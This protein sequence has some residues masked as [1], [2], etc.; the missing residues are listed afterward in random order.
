MTI[1]SKKR[2]IGHARDYDV[3]ETPSGRTL[4]KYSGSKKGDYKKQKFW[5][6][7]R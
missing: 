6:K 5:K 3:Y 1:P 7:L 2:L 4:Y